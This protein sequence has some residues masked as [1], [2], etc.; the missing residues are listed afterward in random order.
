MFAKMAKSSFMLPSVVFVLFIF[1]IGVYQ[2]ANSSSS[3][4]AIHDSCRTAF[5]PVL[6][7]PPTATYQLQRVA[8]VLPPPTAVRL[9]YNMCLP[10]G[11]VV[12]VVI[13]C[14]VWKMVVGESPE[15]L[16]ALR[17]HISAF[18]MLLCFIMQLSCSLS[19]FLRG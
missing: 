11:L 10:I 19:L 4:F 14:F 17:G 7:E 8:W 13:A 16:V 3:V 5:K 2:A 12:L 15:L 18:I 6:H 1:A 9:F